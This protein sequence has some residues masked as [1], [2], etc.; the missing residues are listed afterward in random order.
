MAAMIGMGA[1]YAFVLPP[2]HP[3]VAL[4]I[5]TGWTNTSQV[6]KYGLPLMVIA[7]LAAA[8]V[9]YPIGSALM[10]Y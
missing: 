6:V 7:L 1:S 2:A 9:G 3:N 10:L 5:G 8:F 4:A